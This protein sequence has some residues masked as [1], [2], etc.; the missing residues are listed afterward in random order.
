MSCIYSFPEHRIIFMKQLL[1]VIIV[2]TINAC[3]NAPEKSER[4]DGFTPVLKTKE[5][6][7]YHDVMEGH[8]IG[9]AK[10]GTLRKQLN[11][12]QHELD[13]LSKLPS[14][15]IDQRYKQALLDLQEELNYA[16]HAMF[17]WMQE[18]VVD[19]AIS[20]KDK[21]LLYL[22]SE[23]VKVQK[24]RDN[25]LNSLQRADSLLTK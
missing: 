14:K 25:I 8:D 12:V 2:F 21:R 6:S 20:D 10:M 19:S 1:M 4:K 24:V 17:T 5:D 7:L 15:K 3:S 23:R 11:K 22:E 13:S 9:M 16:D 18:F